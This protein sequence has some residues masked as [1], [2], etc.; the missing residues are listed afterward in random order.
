M[1]YRE[2]NTLKNNKRIFKDLW[3]NN[4]ISSIHIIRMLEGKEKR[5]EF[6]REFGKTIAEKYP[7]L[8]NT[9]TVSSN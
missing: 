1:N 5:G 8:M 6:E 7:N 2:N 4:K 9:P 3:E